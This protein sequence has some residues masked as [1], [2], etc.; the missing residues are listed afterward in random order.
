MIEIATIVM[1]KEIQ[2]DRSGYISD[3]QYNTYI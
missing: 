2:G 3:V 1:F